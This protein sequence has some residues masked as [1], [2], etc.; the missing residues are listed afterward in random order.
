MI[1]S[2]WKFIVAFLAVFLSLPVFNF[3][4][5][6]YDLRSQDPA[7]FRSNPPE[8]LSRTGDMLRFEAA[9]AE[10]DERVVMLG[11]SHVGMG[12]NS[13][14]TGIA[15]FWL[16]AMNRDEVIRLVT[17]LAEH[18]VGDRL[19]IIDIAA[20][21]PSPA[22]ADFLPPFMGSLLSPNT[23]LLSLRK[24]FNARHDPDGLDCLVREGRGT[25]NFN[26][27]DSWKKFFSKRFIMFEEAITEVA[28]SCH[29][30]RVRLAIVW[31]PFYFEPNTLEQMGSSAGFLD[32]S[33]TIDSPTIKGGCPV[34]VLN[35]A[36]QEFRAQSKASKLGKDNENWFDFNHFRPAAGRRYI[37][38]I[39]M[40]MEYPS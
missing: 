18:S 31:F 12:I 17:Q 5:D 9:A 35:L 33:R 40:Q 15:K 37:D 30:P 25:G 32:G 6:P 27:K 21:A 38:S 1:I 26:M 28:M 7:L 24:I 39:L 23:T 13:C 16:P 2:E 3:V 34:T 4:V 14:D 19:I 29:N 22:S 8:T 11:T 10:L 36:S 20:L